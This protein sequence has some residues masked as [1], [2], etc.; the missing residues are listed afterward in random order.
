MPTDHIILWLF[1]NW[2][3][4][5]FLTWSLLGNGVVSACC[6]SGTMALGDD[7]AAWVFCM[8]TENNWKRA[9]MDY[10]KIIVGGFQSVA[11]I[12]WGTQIW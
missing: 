8:Q 5:F 4:L 10:V 2:R 1:T 6:N 9:E 12:C 3:S 11:W 7:G